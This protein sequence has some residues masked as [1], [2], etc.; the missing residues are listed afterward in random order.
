M[1]DMDIALWK[2]KDARAHRLALEE[3]KDPEGVTQNIYIYIYI[4]FGGKIKMRAR[5]GWCWRKK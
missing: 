4:Y 2:N 3:I 5:T 1:D